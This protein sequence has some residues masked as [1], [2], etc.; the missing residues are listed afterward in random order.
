MAGHWQWSRNKAGEEPYTITFLSGG[1]IRWNGKWN[2]GWWNQTVAYFHEPK[3][4]FVCVTVEFA[5]CWGPKR[6]HFFVIEGDRAILLPPNHSVYTQEHLWHFKWSVVHANT[7]T[8]EL[9]KD[10]VTA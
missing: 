10:V 2:R 9:K 3:K 7:E 1:Y 6:R 4:T 8:I 5:A